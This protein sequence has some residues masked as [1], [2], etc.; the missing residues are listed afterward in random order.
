MS[1]W[2]EIAATVVS[3]V[4]ESQRTTVSEVL[5]LLARYW[6]DGKLTEAIARRFIECMVHGNYVEAKKLL[7][8]EMDA[9]ALLEADH[10]ENDR[11]ARMIAEDKQVYDFLDE[12]QMLALKVA[13]G[14]AM[15][16]LA[17]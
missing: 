17:L 13:V 1:D 8:G 5:V 4:P 2:D 15:A 7:Y 16:A 12:L 9:A 11:L 14:V 10:A 3:R 6:G